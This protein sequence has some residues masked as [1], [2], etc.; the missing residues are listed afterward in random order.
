[1]IGRGNFKVKLKVHKGEGVECDVR[2]NEV[3]KKSRRKFQKRI[4]S[5][6]VLQEGDEELGFS[7]IFFFIKISP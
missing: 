2:I 5:S 3:A 4:I 1:M 7:F 6:F